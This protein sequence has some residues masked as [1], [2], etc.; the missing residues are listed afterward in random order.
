MQKMVFAQQADSNGDHSQRKTS[1]WTYKPIGVPMLPMTILSVLLTIFAAA[2]IAPGPPPETARN[3]PV[4]QVLRESDG[5]FFT[6]NHL[7]A[8][9]LLYAWLHALPA[10]VWCVC[11][12]L[13]HVKKIRRSNITVHRWLGR[14]AIVCSLLLSFTG[15]LFSFNGMVLSADVWHVHKIRL[16]SDVKE[17]ITVLAWPSAHIWMRLSAPAFAVSAYMTYHYARK[18]DIVNHQRWAEVCTFIGYVVPLERVVLVANMALAYVLPLLSQPVRAYLQ[19]PETLLHKHQAE[20]A[21]F[22]FSIWSSSLLMLV[23]MT[24]KVRRQNT[25]ARVK[26][27]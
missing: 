15:F 5:S 17:A 11:M 26:Q 12:P 22:S 3:A 23:Y 6:Y 13:Q 10:T 20:Q 19:V 16:G 9:P 27:T 18:R 8:S 1:R 24:V 4:F 25:L 7:R 21:A 14:I 2:L